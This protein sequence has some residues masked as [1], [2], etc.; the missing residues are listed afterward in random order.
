MIRYR[1][2][3]LHCHF[4]LWIC[5]MTCLYIIK[6][7]LIHLH[8]VDNL[9]TTWGDAKFFYFLFY[10]CLV[11]L[12]DK[13]VVEPTYEYYYSI[14]NTL[15]KIYV[16]KFLCLRDI[17]C[18]HII[19]FINFKLYFPYKEANKTFP[20]SST[21]ITLMPSCSEWWNKTPLKL[22]LIVPFFF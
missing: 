20:W 10:F 12:D 8:L 13:R 18:P 2:C 1:I 9:L 19:D 14:I 15:Y 7:K 22:S 21:K 6:K 3:D 16:T 11:S 17:I 4:Y 5:L